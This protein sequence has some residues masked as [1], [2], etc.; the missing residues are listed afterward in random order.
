[1]N[2]Q[3]IRMGYTIPYASKTSEAFELEFP[4][5]K[6][7]GT[8]EIKNISY[9]NDGSVSDGYIEYTYKNLLT[10]AYKLVGMQYSWGDK[11]TDG[12]DCSSTQAAIYNC[13]GFI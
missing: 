6:S 12:L 1:I 2:D 13:F 7:D 3:I 8:L 9:P 4:T 5:R 10:Q 11:I